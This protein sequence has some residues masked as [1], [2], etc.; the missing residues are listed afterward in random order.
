MRLDSLIT[1]DLLLRRLFLFEATEQ[2]SHIPILILLYQS[3]EQF[4]LR[5]FN[6]V[7]I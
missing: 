1:L 6:L 4:R 3:N 5:K 7:R 2:R